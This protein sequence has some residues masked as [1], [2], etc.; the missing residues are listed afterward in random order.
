MRCDCS[1][2]MFTPFLAYISTLSATWIIRKAFEKLFCGLCWVSMV[3]TKE[4]E[5]VRGSKAF[6]K[7]KGNMLQAYKMLVLLIEKKFPVVQWHVG[8]WSKEVLLQ[9]N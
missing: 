4:A 6:V 5:R 7:F 8:F 9:A 1:L 3:D 2:M